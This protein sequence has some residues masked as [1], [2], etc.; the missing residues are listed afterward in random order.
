MADDPSIEHIAHEAAADVTRLL[1]ARELFLSLSCVLCEHLGDQH[2]GP[3]NDSGYR[4][5]NVCVSCT[6]FQPGWPA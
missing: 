4:L 1:K 6:G 2:G 3:P 5:C